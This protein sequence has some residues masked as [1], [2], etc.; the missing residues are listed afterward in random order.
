M[1]EEPRKSR[2]VLGWALAVVSCLGAATVMAMAILVEDGQERARFDSIMFA[3]TFLL[4]FALLAIAIHH[5]N[6][7]SER[8]ED[9]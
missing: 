8:G 4:T 2:R 1:E 9:Q 3:A 5:M 7:T 6:K